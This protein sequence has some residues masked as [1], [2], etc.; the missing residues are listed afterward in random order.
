MKHLKSYK[1]FEELSRKEEYLNLCWTN[2]KI[3]DVLS[4]S[5]IYNYVQELHRNEED[6]YDGDLGERIG[7]FD[8]YV[9]TE[10]KIESIDIEEFELDEDYMNDYI[11]MYKSS[12]NYPPIV[13]DGDLGVSSGRWRNGK[14][15]NLYTIIDGNHRA[16]ALSKIGIKNIKAWVGK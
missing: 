7:Q 8:K 11:D 2:A 15:V 10:V 5:D 3:G 4:E 9:L 14:Y 16:N 6:F 13:L 12:N 1:I